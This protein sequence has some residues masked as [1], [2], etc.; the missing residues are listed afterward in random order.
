MHDEVYDDSARPAAANGAPGQ[1]ADTRNM[2]F[3]AMAGYRLPWLGV[4]PFFGYDFYR[5][6]KIDAAALWGGLNIRPTD[7]IVLKVQGTR[8]WF[9]N[10]FGVIV[11]PSP[12]NYLFA[13]IAWSF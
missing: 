8:V 1:T 13:Q 5:A 4:M 12:A 9:P 6:Y 11:T 3:Y 7:R 2:G 10:G